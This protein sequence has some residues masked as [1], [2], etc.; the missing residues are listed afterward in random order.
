MSAH[1]TKPVTHEKSRSIEPITT[2]TGFAPGTGAQRAPVVSADNLR[3]CAY[4]KWER[5]G[6]PP[7]DG[8]QFWLEAEQELVKGK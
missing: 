3:L 5:A 6:R 1:K 8:I 7:G 4:Q 2:P